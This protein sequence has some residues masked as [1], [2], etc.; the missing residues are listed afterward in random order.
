MNTNTVPIRSDLRADAERPSAG[1]IDPLRRVLAALRRRHRRQRAIA[2]LARMPDWRL[3]H[4]GIPRGRIAEVVDGLL[5]RQ[6]REAV[7]HAEV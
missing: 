1:W 3:E 4:L 5:A 6:G 2:E 7:L